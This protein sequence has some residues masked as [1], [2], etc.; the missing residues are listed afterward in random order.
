MLILFETPRE[1]LGEGYDVDIAFASALENFAGGL[2]DPL[3]VAIGGACFLMTCYEQIYNCSERDSFLQGSSPYTESWMSDAMWLKTISLFQEARKRF[4]KAS[5][6]YDHGYEL[7]QQIQSFINKVCFLCIFIS[8][9]KSRESSYY[10]QASLNEKMIEYQRQVD[11]E[12]R[13]SVNGFHMSLPTDSI[14]PLARTSNKVMEAVMQSAVDGKVHIIR[15]GYLSKRSSNLR[16]DWKRR[17]FVLDSRGMLCYYRKQKGRSPVRH[18]IKYFSCTIFHTNCLISLL[19]CHSLLKMSISQLVSGSPSHHGQRMGA[20]HT[21]NLLTSTI[22]ADADQSDLRFCFRIITP[23][24][25]YTLQYL[26]FGYFIMPVESALDQTDWIE[27]ITRVIASLLSSQALEKVILAISMLAS[28]FGF[29]CSFMILIQ[30]YASLSMPI[31]WVR[32]LTL[33][34]KAWEPSVILLFQSLGNDFANT[35]WEELL[36]LTDES[37]TP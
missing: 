28:G 26:Y 37:S 1:G 25:C 14:Q 4:D 11:R 21:V 31:P 6:A 5:V 32:S 22:K 18:D 2:N 33:D 12:S 24:R 13:Q 30:S 10:E 34:V 8:C 35:V 19:I 15:Q 23:S 29:L 9:T 17:L 3:A 27:K 36:Q 7:L 20:H 16:G